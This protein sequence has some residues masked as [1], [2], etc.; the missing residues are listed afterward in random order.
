MKLLFVALALVAAAS[1]YSED[2][3]PAHMKDRLDRYI[4]LKKVWQEKWHA[5]SEA[6]RLNYENVILARIDQLPQIHHQRI[7]DR[8][9]SMPEE[10]RV[11]LLG[12]LRR[13]F[14]QEEGVE[15]DNEIEEIDS[16]VQSLP[17]KLREKLQ[18]LIRVQFQEA[19]AYS[20]DEVSSN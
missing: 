18:D 17:D 6:E 12:Y 16:I 5:M 9:E 19:T 20:V 2:D 8:I 14:P 11:K 3:I 7:H 13:R 10:H 1:A 15:F 4:A